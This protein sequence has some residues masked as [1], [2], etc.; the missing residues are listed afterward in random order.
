MTGG[1]HASRWARGRIRTRDDRR[2][3]TDDTADRVDQ[4]E[5]H[6]AHEGPGQAASPHGLPGYTAT[7]RSMDDLRRQTIARVLDMPMAA[8]IGLA[9]SLGDDDLARFERTSGLPREEARRRLRQQ[10]ESGRTASRAA[11]MRDR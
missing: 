6:D 2:F 8:R 4:H 10:R 9:L 11:A 7:M 3:A 5:G 1:G